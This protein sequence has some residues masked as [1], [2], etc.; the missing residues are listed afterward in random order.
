MYASLSLFADG[1]LSFSNHWRPPNADLKQKFKELLINLSPEKRM[2]YGHK[3]SVI[4]RVP[5]S[6]VCYWLIF[7][8][9]DRTQLPQLSRSPLVSMSF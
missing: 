1:R 8:F 3:T 6:D 9:V 7:F 4:V 5:T 2:F